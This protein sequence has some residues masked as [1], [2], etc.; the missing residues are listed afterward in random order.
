MGL[1]ERLAVREVLPSLRRREEVPAQA[2]E[3]RIAEPYEDDPLSAARGAVYGIFLGAI[4]W[5][6]ILWLL[7]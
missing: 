7:I 4:I 1:I 5:G 3:G 2:P 6:V